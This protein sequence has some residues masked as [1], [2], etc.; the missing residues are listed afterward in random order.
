MS[1][2]NQNL[3]R[4][5]MNQEEE[6]KNPSEESSEKLQIKKTDS[7]SE[8]DVK[9]DDASPQAQ[10]SEPK[11]NKLRVNKASSLSGKSCP[12]CGAPMGDE[13]I[14][15]VQCGYNTKTK[16]LTQHDT[17]DVIEKRGGKKRKKLKLSHAIIF[18]LAAVAAYAYFNQPQANL[19]YNKYLRPAY[20]ASL[21][22]IADV[23]PDSWEEKL[24]EGVQKTLGGTPFEKELR[25]K[26]DT[27]LPL[28]TVGDK[29]TFFFQGNKQ[30][31]AIFK[32]IENGKITLKLKNGEE[33]TGKL[34]RLELKSRAQCRKEDRERYFQRLLKKAQKQEE[35]S[36]ESADKKG[37]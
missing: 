11:K 33:I 36:K 16:E 37:E 4:D 2:S 25:K 27:R 21:Q 17:P 5:D 9:A 6:K 35:Q 12:S 22:W 23:T 3:D 26:M 32:G 31:K 19:Y 14:I 20:E 34:K 28:L 10:E 18:L 30:V 1:T 29:A 24:P 8:S 13:D 15:C 7:D